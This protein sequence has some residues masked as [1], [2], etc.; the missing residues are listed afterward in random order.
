MSGMLEGLVTNEWRPDSALG[1]W[2]YLTDVR[3]AL[4]AE[5]DRLKADEHTAALDG[6]YY[7]GWNGA[8]SE[9]RRWAG[10]DQ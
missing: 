1:P 3:E 5:L 9:V 7:H 6:G 10:D 8:L 4:L 2:V